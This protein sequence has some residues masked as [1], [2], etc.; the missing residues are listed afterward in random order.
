MTPFEI[1][2][3]YI[4]HW[5]NKEFD[6]LRELLADDC[7]FTGPLATLN[8]ADDCIAGLAGMSQIV[9]DIVVRSR[10]AD[11]HDVITWFDLHTSVASPAPTA[12]WAHID[13]GL[14]TAINVTFDPRG[15]VQSAK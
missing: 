11:D 7:T 9:T 8:S 12:N 5:K 3:A 13:H 10:V 15:I 14:I 1:G 2:Q 4:D 6:A